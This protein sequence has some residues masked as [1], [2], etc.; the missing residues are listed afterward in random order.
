MKLVLSDRVSIDI[1]KIQNVLRLAVSVVPCGRERLICSLI[2]VWC[3]PPNY[4]LFPQNVFP[5][6][7]IS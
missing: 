4:W 7:P 5:A 1:P 3:W 2:V 6:K